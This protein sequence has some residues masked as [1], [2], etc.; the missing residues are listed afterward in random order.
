[1][2]YLTVRQA[3]ERLEVHP[4]TVSQWIRQGYFPGAYKRGPTKTSP[5]AIPEADVDAFEAKL[6]NPARP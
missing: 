5:Y 2:A 1:M 4:N 6:K 3:A